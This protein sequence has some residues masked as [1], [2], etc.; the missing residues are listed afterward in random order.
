MRYILHEAIAGWLGFAL[1]LLPTV[2]STQCVNLVPNGSFETFSALP[3]DDCDWSLATGWTNAATTSLCGPENGT[4]DYYHLLSPGGFASTLPG[5]FYATGVNPF[6]GDAVMG[7]AGFSIASANDREYI[8]TA[9]S[10]PLVPGEEY[11]LEFRIT[12]GIP[13]AG[14]FYTNGWGVAL[15]TAPLLQNAGTNDV[16]TS[17]LPQFQIGGIVSNNDWELV[18]FTFVA[19]GAFDYLTFG[20]YLTDAQITAQQHGGIN[21]L[22]LSYLFVDDFSIVPTAGFPTLDLGPDIFGC[23]TGGSVTLSA[24]DFPCSNYL[25]STGAT[26]SSITVSAAGTYAVSVTGA[27]GL[28]TDEIT[29]TYGSDVFRT[30]DAQTCAGTPYVLNGQ[31]YSMAGT[32]MQNLPAANGCDSI[33]TVNLSI[34]PALTETR[35]VQTCAGTPY[36]LN[37]QTYTLAGTYQQNFTAANGC[38]SVLTLELSIAPRLN[39]TLAVQTCAGVPYMLNGQSYSTAGSYVQ[40]LTAAGGCDSVLTLELSV[41][42]NLTETITAQTCFGRPYVLNGQAYTVAGSYVQ[43]LTSAAGCPYTLNLELSVAPEVTEILPARTCAG[44]PYVLNGQSYIA[45]GSYQQQLIAAN[46]CD[47]T[48]LLELMVDSPSFGV[49]NAQT[50]PGTPYLLNGASYSAAGTYVQNLTAANGCDSTLTVNLTLALPATATLAAQTCPGTPYMLNGQTY[51]AAG[52]YVQN[53]TAVNGCDST[54][55]INLTFAAALTGTLAAQTCPGTPYVLNGQSYSAAGTYQ[56]NL[57]AV[58]GCDSLLTI[59]LAVVPQLTQT[60]SAQTCP[61]TPYVLNGQSYGSAGTY[62]QNLTAANGC[63][64]VLTLQLAVS[65]VLTETLSAQTCTG[66]TYTLNGQMY[67]TAGTYVQN[68][69]AT[70]GCDSVL[71]LVLTVNNPTSQTIVAQTCAGV[72]YSLNGQSYVVAGSYVQNLASAA[73]CDSTL[74][75][76]L[77]ISPAPSRIINAQTCTGRSYFLNGQEYSMAGSYI[78]SLLAANGCDSTIILILTTGASNPSQQVTAETC[79]GTPFIL[80]GETYTTGGNYIQTLSAENGCDSILTLDLTVLPAPSRTIAAQTCPGTPY[81]LNGQSYST[82]GNYVQS[83]TAANGCDSILTIQLSVG[84]AITQTVAAQ[85]CT[86]ISYVLN[87][88]SYAAAGTYQQNLTAVNGCDSVLTLELTVVPSLGGTLTAQICDGTSY[89][90][91]GQSYSTGGSYVQNLTAAN[92]C[93]ST[94]TL[95]LSVAAPTSE[96]IAAQTCTGT[97]YVLNGQS[98]SAAGS[99]VQNLTSVNGCDSTLT[100]EL[101]ITESASETVA[102]Q[103]CPGTPYQLNGRTYFIAGTYVQNLTAVNGCDSTLTIELSLSTSAFETIVAQTCIGTPYELNGQSFDEAGSYV[104]FLTAVNGCDSFL[105]LELSITPTLTERIT[106][107]TCAGT[108]YVLNGQSYAI[109]GIYEQNLT[110]VNG[111]DSVITLELSIAPLLQETVSAQTCI[112][113]PY[114]LNGQSYSTGGIFVQTLTAANG[115]DSILTL[116]LFVA[117][118]TN[119]T[120]VAQTCEGT[121]YILNG[122]AYTMGGSYVIDLPSTNG[123]EFTLTLELTVTP[124]LDEILVAETCAGT[125]YLLNGLAYETAG[126]YVQNLLSQDGC[127]STLTLQLSV[128]P[129]PEETVA[130]QTCTGTPYLLNGQAYSTAGSYVQNLISAAGCDSTLTLELEILEP[131]SEMIA[132]R[133]CDGTPYLLNGQSYVAAG[134]YVQT[135]TAVNGCDSTLTLELM[136][137]ALASETIAGRTCAD[138]PYILNGQSYAATGNYVQTLTAANGCDSMLTLELE[139]DALATETI[140]VRTCAGSPYLLNGQSYMSAGSYVQNLTAANGCDSTLTLELMVDA[141]ASETL[142]AQTCAGTPYL[143]NGQSYATTGSYVQNL[144]AVNGCDSTLMLELIVTAPTTE[145]IDARICAGTSYELNGQSYNSAGSYVQTLTAAG[146]CDSL[147]MLELAVLPERNETVAAETCPGS[148]YR[149]NGQSYASAGR[150]VQTLMAVNGCDSTLT[151]ELTFTSDLNETLSAQ[152]CRDTPYLLNGQSYLLAGTYFQQLTTENGCDSTLRLELTVTPTSTGTISAT[153]PLGGFLSFNGEQFDRPGVYRQRLTT[154][155]G[156]DSLLTINLFQPEET[157]YV[158]TAFSPNDDGVNDRFLPLDRLNNGF[159]IQTLSIY[160]RWGGRVYQEEIDG[161]LEAV[162]GWDGTLNDRPVDPGV[163]V[164]VIV[165]EM[166][167]GERRV[168]KGSVTVVR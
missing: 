45:A 35:S 150:Y 155:G 39:G 105:T 12:T 102:A 74:T 115:C 36:T 81:V 146:G 37:G 30:I 104:Q 46:G 103:T 93:D 153:L 124:P 22:G 95:E 97:P 48:L 66:G 158:P 62:Q 59:Q 85:T 34:V 51:S 130:A 108:P 68:L 92:G 110:A 133:T 165:L 58:N 43:N 78:Q 19:S 157:V 50:C 67:G 32:Y 137:D 60:I 106:A 54:L 82:A 87:G 86:G 140:A 123:C 28:L 156:C 83:L 26:N 24:G 42:P 14:G 23:G 101:T 15:T 132:A 47:S 122:Q 164:Y 112:G 90:L 98:Y 20:N 151:L 55:T 18:T 52:T 128:N 27:C 76:E 136:V 73:G 89:V 166:P 88:Q 109:A 44:T 91:N 139:V 131:A 2:A 117:Q 69:T 99:Y 162:I 84:A 16:I 114:V 141:L 64:S 127:D 120:L 7:V 143:L 56:Q 161:P 159:K 77:S 75:L 129:L 40:N 5:N 80:N 142:S 144:T 138:T 94:L 8:S 70:N 71:T 1:L 4:P 163:Y 148:I 154:F 10:C 65:S 31:T 63:D 147:L 72:P 21:Q 38:D 57:T 79:M 134:S 53:L 168:L 13:D 135:L 3:D 116:E 107:Q 149:F 111:C 11:R 96:T 25:W 126:S 33:L 118:T 119:Q 125:P 61:G 100:L 29:I 6:D 145:T 121:P 113:T 49:L 167:D 9:L 41:A 17:V 152:T 160:N